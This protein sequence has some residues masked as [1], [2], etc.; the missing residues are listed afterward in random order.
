MGDALRTAPYIYSLKFMFPMIAVK[1]FTGIF[2]DLY[3][4]FADARI[5]VMDVY[6]V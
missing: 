3:K 1:H 2:C 5:H 4:V 6:C